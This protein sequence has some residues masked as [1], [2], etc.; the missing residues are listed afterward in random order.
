MGAENQSALPEPQIDK[1][2]VADFEERFGI[3]RDVDLQE[4][5]FKLG[6]IQSNYTAENFET[7]LSALAEKYADQAVFVKVNVDESEEA[8]MAHGISSIPNVIAFKGG[9]AVANQLGFVPEGAL[10]AFIQSVL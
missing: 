6:R 8:A 1:S 9:K 2:E 7:E 4:W 5:F 10:E 3:S